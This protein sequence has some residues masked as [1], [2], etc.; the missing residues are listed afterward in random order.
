MAFKKFYPRK[1]RAM[2]K[3]KTMYR[4]KPVVT[5]AVKTYVKRSL[6]RRIENKTAGVTGILY[7]YQNGL[8][9]IVSSQLVSLA[10]SIVQGVTE[11][12]RIAN[13][14]N[15]KYASMRCYLQLNGSGVNGQVPFIPGNFQVRIFIGRLKNSISTP[16]TTDLD[17]LLRTGAA[18][19]P[20][21]SSDGLSLC[22]RTNK[23]L[24][25]IYY[26]RIHKIGVADPSAGGVT[27]NTITGI[28][29]NEYR[30]NKTFKINITRMF[31]KKLIF[32]DASSNF[33]Q[34]SGLYM[35]AGIV[36]SLTSGYINA[37]APV[38]MYYDLEYSFEDA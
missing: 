26:D 8:S 16:L 30:L 21:N 27:Y 23:D 3:K 14:V 5:R 22:R 33:P 10:P 20:F 36:D 31:R 1:K 34:N 38:A 7:A 24:F 29:N 17:K 11:S 13:L 37:A 25:T 12:N 6:D 18:T 35:W 32:N 15:L 4:K 2:P 19:L 28:G 9:S